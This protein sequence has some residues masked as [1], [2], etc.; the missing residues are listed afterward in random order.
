M[1]NNMSNPRE[2]NK[3]KYYYYIAA[4]ISLILAILF[5]I[6]FIPQDSVSYLS[7]IS[8]LFVVFIFVFFG[9]TLVSAFQ[10]NSPPIVKFFEGVFSNIS[11]YQG[12]QEVHVRVASDTQ[13]AVKTLFNKFSLLFLALSILLINLSSNYGY[14]SIWTLFIIFGFSIN[15]SIKNTSTYTDNHFQNSENLFY[16]IIGLF[17]LLLVSFSIPN[18]PNENVFGKY[19]HKIIPNFELNSTYAP[20]DNDVNSFTVVPNMSIYTINQA[21]SINF[22]RFNGDKSSDLQL[23][24]VNDQGSNTTIKNGV[25][26]DDIIRGMLIANNNQKEAKNISHER[27]L[28]EELNNASYEKQ[29]FY[30]KN[31]NDRSNVFWI[32][33]NITY[34]E[35][36]PLLMATFISFLAF[37]FSILKL[38][39]AFDA[40]KQ[41]KD[42]K[43]Y[44]EK[45]LAILKY[46]EVACKDKR[47]KELLDSI[48]KSLFNRKIKS[49]SGISASENQGLLDDIESNYMKLDLVDD[50]GLDKDAILGESLKAIEDEF[51]PRYDN[52]SEAYIN[53]N[54]LPYSKKHRQMID[55]DFRDCNE[56]AEHVD[57]GMHVGDMLDIDPHSRLFIFIYDFIF[58]VI[59]IYFV[60]V[61]FTHQWL[62][63]EAAV[64][65]S[66][67]GVIMYM[68]RDWMNNLIAGYII[69][70]DKLISLGE[71]IQIPE[72]NINGFVVEITQSNF[73]IA[74]FGG[75]EVSLPIS[76]AISKPFHSYKKTKKSGHRIKRRMMINIRSIKEIKI[77]DITD[78]DIKDKVTKACN[79]PVSALCSNLELFRKYI[80]EYLIDQPYINNNN[81]LMVRELDATEMGVPI[82]VYAFVEPLLS[83]YSK[84]ENHGACIRHYDRVVYEAVQSEIFEHLIRAARAFK[85]EQFQTESDSSKEKKQGEKIINM[86]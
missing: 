84:D 41:K 75:T 23:I 3:T 8:T 38:I 13:I 2:E 32:K 66:V 39:I 11:S 53:K 62:P 45:I 51:L 28:I 14:L 70:R 26:S 71:W 6:K 65:S 40:R 55:I 43:D 46:A 27:G 47:K 17:L 34:K 57:K 22:D 37:I 60:I 52:L 61:L 81:F 74:N 85:L 35:Y 76:D 68:N 1:K 77:E 79:K 54:L 10:E 73:K 24:R 69:W 58:S 56:S 59:V 49:L 42:S 82:E 33:N 4:I 83:V 67:A 64:V 72:D 16:E 50:E 7:V 30:L 19:W 78:D 29:Y 18:E 80:T 36:W 31:T 48:I 44:A 25:L 15:K 86:V 9:W 20:T 21:R 5:V 63:T 12:D